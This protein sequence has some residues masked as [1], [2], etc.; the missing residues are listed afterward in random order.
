MDFLHLLKKYA[1]RILSHE[2]GGI[3]DD[4]RHLREKA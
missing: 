3:L 1:I 2:T 4:G